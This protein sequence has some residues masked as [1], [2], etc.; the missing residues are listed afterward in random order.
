MD[1]QWPLEASHPQDMQR[2]GLGPDFSSSPQGTNSHPSSRQS[3]APNSL[4]TSW[5]F[6]G[7]ITKQTSTWRP[8]P[9]QTLTSRD[10]SLSTSPCWMHL[11]RY[12]SQGLGQDQLEMGRVR[13][14]QHTVMSYL[15]AGAP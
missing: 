7:G 9:S 11:T 3:W 14:D 12:I 5:T 2:L 8:S 4:P 15:P 6:Q 13:L 1:R 10:W